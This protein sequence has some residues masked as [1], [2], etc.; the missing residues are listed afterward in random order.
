MSTTDQL[1]R[2]MRND[3]SFVGVF[4]LNRIPHLNSSVVMHG[5]IVN[6][7]TDN[8]PGQHWIAVRIL[9]DRAWIFD[10]LPLHPPPPTLCDHLLHHCNIRSL[11]ICTLQVQPPTS[12]TCG[13]HCVYFLNMLQ[14]APSESAVLEYISK[15]DR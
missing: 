13:H 6:T 14:P 10:P 9:F 1:T 4:P 15:L 11:Y 7:Q 3:P 2:W 8:L 5:L 12:Q